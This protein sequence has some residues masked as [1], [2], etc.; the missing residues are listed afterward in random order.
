MKTSYSPLDH[1]KIDIANSFGLDKS[2]YTDRL[3]WAETHL[4]ELEEMIPEAKEPSMFTAGILALRD[5]QE[6]NASGYL[7]SRDASASGI[8]ILSVLS[9]CEAGMRNTGVISDEDVRP[10]IY[11]KLGEMVGD[12]ASPSD[13]KQALMTFFYGSSAKPKEVFGDDLDKFDAAAKELAPKAYML[14]DALV[15]T[16]DPEA[17]SHDWIMPDGFHCHI[18]VWDTVDTRIEVPHL[19]KKTSFT[20]RHSVNTPIQKGLANA[21]NI[22]HACDA[23]LV[24][25]MQGR[26]NYD[27]ELFEAVVVETRQFADVEITDRTKFLSVEEVY[28]M[29]RTSNDPQYYARVHELA[30][31]CLEGKAF[32]I[33]TIHD[34]FRAHPNNVQRMCEMYNYILWEM[35]HSDLLWDILSQLTGKTYKIPAFDAKVAQAI[36]DSEYSI[37]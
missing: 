25:E 16:W 35:Y 22:T 24:R 9:R 12:Y 14:R 32:P 26:L 8:A 5:T 19:D 37:N 13:A 27:Q 28:N 33:L 2:T 3:L 15:N 10:N 7:C 31:K 21:A 17:L 36:L 20:F 23:L 18:R 11:G 34:A 30:S 29:D 4:D 1:L 6:G